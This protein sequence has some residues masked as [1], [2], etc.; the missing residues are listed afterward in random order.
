MVRIC[1]IILIFCPRSRIETLLKIESD[2][3]SSYIQPYRSP[4]RF[5]LRKTL[6]LPYLFSSFVSFNAEKHFKMVLKGQLV[7][8]L[9]AQP[10]VNA[11]WS[12]TKQ[13]KAC[14]KL[15]TIQSLKKL[16]VIIIVFSSMCSNFCCLLLKLLLLLLL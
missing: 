13:V 14:T 16:I 3:T 10:Q 9:N 8:M 15:N 5:S 2:N 12:C 11:T 6:R 4:K 1:G 7:K